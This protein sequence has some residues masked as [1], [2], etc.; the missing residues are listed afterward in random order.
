MV[1]VIVV[2]S[3][4]S[5]EY[6]GCGSALQKCL[7]LPVVSRLLLALPLPPL[8]FFS[9]L[10]EQIG[11]VLLLT[12]PALVAIVGVVAG[13]LWRVVRAAVADEQDGHN[14]YYLH[15]KVDIQVPT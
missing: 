5:G 3:C 13:E 12:H 1:I 6:G 7:V 11:A 4:G 10:E 14:N 8:L 2:L 15:N 9:D